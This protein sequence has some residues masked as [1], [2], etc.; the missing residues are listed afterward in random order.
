MLDTRW[1]ATSYST[2]GFIPLPDMVRA[3]CERGQVQVFTRGYKRYRVSRQRYSARPMTVEFILLTHTRMPGT[4]SP[5][6]IVDE[7]RTIEAS[8]NA[9]AG[10]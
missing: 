2:D 5:D 6:E 9:G 1:V 3:N 7:I 10:T 4:R 8:L